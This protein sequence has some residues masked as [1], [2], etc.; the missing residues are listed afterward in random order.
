MFSLRGMS[1]VGIRGYKVLA[2]ETSCD[3][4]AVSIICRDRGVLA[5]FVASQHALHASKGGIVPYLAAEAHRKTLPRIVG[6]TLKQAALQIHD[7]D[8]WCATRGP[9]IA[10][11]LTVGYDAGKLLAAATSRPFL[12]IHHMVRISSPSYLLLT[13]MPCRKVT[14]SSHG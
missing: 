8:V 12:A 9:G 3:D 6:L 14:L 7:I 5:E 4:T 1:R 2:I 10:G 13:G 11:C